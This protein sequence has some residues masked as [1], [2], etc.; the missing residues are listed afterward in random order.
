MAAGCDKFCPS[1]PQKS[2][3]VHQAS[4]FPLVTLFLP[5]Q[6]T[7]WLMSDRPSSTGARDVLVHGRQKVTVLL[8]GPDTSPH[9]QNKIQA[10]LCPLTQNPPP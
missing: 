7:M 4:C 6:L 9:L 3:T 8:P 2:S 10:R 1:L 5:G